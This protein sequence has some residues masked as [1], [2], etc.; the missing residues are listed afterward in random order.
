MPATPWPGRLVAVCLQPSFVW[1]ILGLQPPLHAE[2]RHHT[3]ANQHTNTQQ[4]TIAAPNLAHRCNR[5]RAL[6]NGTCWA[7]VPPT[8]SPAGFP[9]VTCT[10]CCPATDGLAF[11]HCAALR[12]LTTLLPACFT[13][14]D[15][16]TPNHK[17]LEHTLLTLCDNRKHIRNTPHATQLAH[18]SHIRYS[19]PGDIC[20]PHGARTWHLLGVGT[21]SVIV[22]I[23]L[24]SD[25]CTF[26]HIM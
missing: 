5:W 3:A 21:A 8:T 24:L 9:Y 11:Q 18:G 12:A 20:C 2:G 23:V 19:D 13:N 17:Y 6:Q 10:G 25:C 26:T 4:L 16:H 14:W 15:M 7:A 1:F 22:S